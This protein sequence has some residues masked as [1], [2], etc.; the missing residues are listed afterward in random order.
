M[1]V[2]YIIPGTVFY[3]P[4]FYKLRI[5]AVFY[6]NNFYSLCYGRFSKGPKNKQQ[7]HIIYDTRQYCSILMRNEFSKFV[8]QFTHNRII[9]IKFTFAFIINRYN[10]VFPSVDIGFKTP[11]A[12]I[13]Y[14]QSH[15]ALKKVDE[16]C[17]HLKHCSNAYRQSYTKQLRFDTNI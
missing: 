3:A 12:N 7:I 6:L 11:M 13:L 16:I 4:G 1:Q 5:H 14:K 10:F 17:H 8:Y 2:S 15:K 9:I